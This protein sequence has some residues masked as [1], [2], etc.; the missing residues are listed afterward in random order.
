MGGCGILLCRACRSIPGCSTTTLTRLGRPSISTAPIGRLTAQ[1][2]GNLRATTRRCTGTSAVTATL[3]L[4]SRLRASCQGPTQ[5]STTSCSTSRQ[6]PATSLPPATT[7][8]VTRSGSWPSRPPSGI[9]RGWSPDACASC[10]LF[11]SNTDFLCFSRSSMTCRTRISSQ[12]P[13]EAAPRTMARSSRPSTT[14]I[15]APLAL[16]WACTRWKR[17]SAK[18]SRNDSA[19]RTSSRSPSLCSCLC[20]R[21]SATTTARVRRT[22][23]SIWQALCALRRP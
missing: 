3:P 19:R 12:C 4:R 6:T 8:A 22:R 23:G 11:G 14:L 9:R 10:S 2:S 13:A 5:R 15:C 16:W 18:S 7:S 17:W 20:F 1:L 21:R